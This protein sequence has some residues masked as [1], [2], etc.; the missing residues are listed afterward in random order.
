M[1]ADEATIGIAMLRFEL[2]GHVIDAIASGQALARFTKHRTGLAEA[3][4]VEEQVG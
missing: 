4:V 1:N 2:D 3:L